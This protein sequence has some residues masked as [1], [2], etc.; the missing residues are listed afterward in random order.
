MSTSS[1]YSHFRVSGISYTFRVPRGK[2]G[3]KNPLSK[4]YI[5]LLQA[6]PWNSS[7]R[8]YF[9]AH[10]SPSWKRKTCVTPLV[11]GRQPISS[12]SPIGPRGKF[13]QANSKPRNWHTAGLMRSSG[14]MFPFP[15]LVSCERA[16]SLQIWVLL[17][18]WWKSY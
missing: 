8:K 9:S 11:Q 2:N 17:L 15:S 3:Y 7:S 1:S 16:F 5:L 4:S 6:I 14:R 12:A 18:N 13:K 10:V